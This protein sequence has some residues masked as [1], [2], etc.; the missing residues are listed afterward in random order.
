MNSRHPSLA[1]VSGADLVLVQRRG[2]R[3]PFKCLGDVRASQFIACR[4]RP[5]IHACTPRP[6]SIR[7]LCYV[8]SVRIVTSTDHQ[9]V[10]V[11]EVC[12]IGA[13]AKRKVR[14]GLG[15]NF[16]SPPAADLDVA[17]RSRRSAFD[18]SRPH[19][20]QSGSHTIGPSSAKRRAQRCG[21]P[22]GSQ[23]SF[24]LQT[25]GPLRCFY[26]NWTYNCAVINI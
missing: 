10:G 14:F 15:F 7:Q 12:V 20:L 4:E 26:V 19:M 1:D 13:G 16:L 9:H 5:E 17:P 3:N 22:S 6:K 11:R 18:P 2:S 25:P 23:S 8:A 24:W 21:T